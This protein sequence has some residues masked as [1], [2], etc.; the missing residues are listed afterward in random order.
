MIE[1]STLALHEEGMLFIDCWL[2][3][4][5]GYIDGQQPHSSVASSYQTSP[6]LLFSPSILVL[7]GHMIPLV[8]LSEPSREDIPSSHTAIRTKFQQANEISLPVSVN[9]DQTLLSGI[10]WWS[11]LL[12]HDVYGKL[13]HSRSSGISALELSPPHGFVMRWRRIREKDF[14][15]ASIALMLQCTQLIGHADGLDQCC[16]EQNGKIWIGLKTF[17]GNLVALR[18]TL[19]ERNAEMAVEDLPVTRELEI[20]IQCSDIADFSAV[21]S[22][23]CVL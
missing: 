8:S 2:V 9:S 23:I 11:S 6:H 18:F 16:R 5:P 19:G 21:R 7:Q 3:F 22:E 14:N 17:N 13:M 1:D 12:T 10:Q 4:Q 15:A 20:S